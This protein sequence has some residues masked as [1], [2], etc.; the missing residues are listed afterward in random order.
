MNMSEA[1]P[2]IDPTIAHEGIRVQSSA[3]CH[4]YWEGLPTIDIKLSLTD[5]TEKVIQLSRTFGMQ[6]GRQL[7]LAC[8]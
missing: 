3:S 6:L 5:G 4:P 2:F 8:A 7:M 1:I